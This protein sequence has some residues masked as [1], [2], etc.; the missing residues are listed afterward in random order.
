A[1]AFVLLIA[2]AN[3]ANLQLARGAARQREIAI[4][5]ALGAGRIRLVRQLLTE[6][7]VLSLVGGGLGITFAVALKLLLVANSRR[8]VGYFKRASLDTV[9]LLVALAVS[10]ITG[11]VVGLVPA[12]HGSRP[13]LNQSLK[14]GGRSS[15]SQSHS[16]LRSSLVAAEVALSIVLLA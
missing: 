5:V 16:F 13:A 3:V 1:V 14:E 10:V 8:N 12:F 4:R 7:V 6:S 2:W 11:I 9:V 15:D